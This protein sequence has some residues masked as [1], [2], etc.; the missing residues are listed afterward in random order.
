MQD[1]IGVHVEGRVVTHILCRELSQGANDRE[2]TGSLETKTTYLLQ[3]LIG[4]LGERIRDLPRSLFPGRQLT[5]GDLDST[6]L[7]RAAK[8]TKCM[9]RKSIHLFV[10][11]SN[12]VLTN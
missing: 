5:I 2:V 3:G 9:V 11:D 7:L 8:P 10:K 4:V 1:Y 12:I 6:V